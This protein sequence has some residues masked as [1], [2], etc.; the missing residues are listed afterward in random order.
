MHN[1][2]WFDKYHMFDYPDIPEHVVRRHVMRSLGNVPS[3][4]RFASIFEPCVILSPQ[5]IYLA[6]S[7][8]IDSFTK[9]EGGDGIA[10]GDYVHIASG[11][12]L[13]I[14]GGRLI[15]ERGSACSSGV[16]IV[17]G[18][19][20]PAPDHSRSC[21]AVAPDAVVSK[22]FVHIKRNAIIFCNAVILP[23]VTIGEGAVIA[24]GAVVNRDVPDHETWGG[25]P[26]R[27]LK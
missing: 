11:V 21:S 2:M 9:L 25:V 20:V 3:H 14:G 24:A 26:A 8:R 17:T 23:G 18:S 4:S 22:S 16:R 15:M 5:N 13:N 12:S 7:V 1:D 27:R 10:L 6:D 19:N